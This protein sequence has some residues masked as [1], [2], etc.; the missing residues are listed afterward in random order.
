[1]AAEIW[2]HAD[3]IDYLVDALDLQSQSDRVQRMVRAA[4][5]TAYRDLPSVYDWNYLK[6]RGQILLTAPYATGTIE[7][8]HAGGASARLVTLTAG[9]FPSWARYGT[10]LIN[11]VR[12]K[13]AS[14]PSSTTLTLDEL[15]NPGEDV[16]AGTTYSLARSQYPLPNGFKRIETLYDTA[17]QFALTYVDPATIHSMSMLQK[18]A[19]S[20]LWWTIRGV[21][22]DYP[23]Q[24]ALEVHPPA[25]SQRTIEFQMENACRALMMPVETQNGTVTTNGTAVTGT[26]TTFPASCVGGIIRFSSDATTKPSA[27]WGDNPYSHET[28]I[29]ARA[30]TT[31]LTL[32]DA[33]SETLTGVAYTISD[34]LDV[35]PGPMTSY[36]LTAAEA[37]ISMLLK[38]DQKHLSVRIANRD[39][40]LQLAMAA[41]YPRAVIPICGNEGFADWNLSDWR[42]DA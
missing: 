31:A 29:I 33:P 24:V 5:R 21:A 37:Q 30:S 41:D 35:N 36:F 15:L 42:S 17:N 38:E 39:A 2:T 10:L 34:P 6:R 18:Q 40:A 12:Y 23:G 7:Y 22:T 26:D 3:A 11:D 27:L 25:S 16:V 9:T 19:G 32:L 14:N 1:M 20:P 28:V 13:V 4:V 8:D